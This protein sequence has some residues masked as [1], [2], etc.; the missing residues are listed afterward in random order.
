MILGT[1]AMSAI[2]ELKKLSINQAIIQN[3]LVWIKDK[4]TNVEKLEARLEE[5]EKDYYG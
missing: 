3:D 2:A 1:G 4:L 5:L